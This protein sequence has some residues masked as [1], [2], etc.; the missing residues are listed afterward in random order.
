MLGEVLQRE[1]RQTPVPERRESPFPALGAPGWCLQHHL[2]KPI[3]L[4]VAMAV[5]RY[6]GR[7]RKKKN[8]IYIRLN[9]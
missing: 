5:G 4:S 9:L 8:Y 2:P 3:P 6:F 1:Q 7:K